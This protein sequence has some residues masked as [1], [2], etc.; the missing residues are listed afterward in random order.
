MDKIYIDTS[1]IGGCFDEEFEEWS[2]KLIN[3]F[4]MGRKIAIISEI[5]LKELEEA[6]K[7]VRDIIQKIPEKSK[8]IILLSDEA[9]E[10]SNKYLMEKVVSKNHLIDT[11]HIALATL[12]KVDILVSWNFKH[13]VNL[14]R[15]RKYNSV[16][17]KYGYPLLEIRT[18]RE[19]L[20]EK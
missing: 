16:N 1:V 2:I 14:N 15:I 12:N 11:R 10:L 8:E 5:T 7:K 19:I 3:E 18:P 9:I 4:I 13:I 17:L 6:P 20:D